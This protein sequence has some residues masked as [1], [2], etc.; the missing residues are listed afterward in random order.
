MD[1]GGG[2]YKYKAVF[3]DIDG[4]LLNS[5]HQVT[6][7]TRKEILRLQREGVPFVLV[8][9]RMPQ[10]MIP[11]QNQIGIRTPM[12]CYGGG[13]VLDENGKTLYSR[14]I[15]LGQAME[16]KDLLDGEFPQLCCN[17]YGGG[18]WVVDD[19]R[20]PWVLKEEAITALKAR[21]GHMGEE[22]AEAGGIHKFLIMGEE[23]LI[24]E[25]GERLKEL[26]PHLSICPSS[27]VYMEVMQGGV[28]K[29]AGVE[30]LCRHLGI[31]TE[32]AIAFGDGGNDIDMLKTVGRSYAMGNAPA[33]VKRSAD[34]VTGD[35]DHEGLLAA[36]RE[37]FRQ[38]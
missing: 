29:G 30:V 20:N 3:S 14:C 10:G 28:N 5:S 35:N 19:D 2:T 32:E 9:A 17:I 23:R 37:N 26:Y 12:V 18:K 8:S 25:A 27:S 38:R 13:L 15:S 11:I 6:E 21:K 24:Q 36:L 22:F 1:K 4:T 31:G 7:G 16:I 33:D 34:H